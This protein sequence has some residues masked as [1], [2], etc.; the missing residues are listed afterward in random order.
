MKKG[1]PDARAA[2]AGVL[3]DG[4]L[5]ACGGFGLCGIPEVLIL[6]VRDSGVKNLTF[7]SNNA[8]VDGW[9]CSQASTA[10]FTSRTAPL[11]MATAS[12]SVRRSAS[13]KALFRAMV[14]AICAASNRLSNR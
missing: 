5:I 7:V 11:G 8:G 14:S 12:T 13:R 4:M 2:L 1:Y 10:A 3:K 9:A 6:A